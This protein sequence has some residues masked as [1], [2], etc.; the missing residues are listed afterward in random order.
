ML[1]DAIARVS[2]SRDADSLLDH[3]V[4]TAVSA[5]GAERGFLLLR[6]GADATPQVRVARDRKGRP[7]PAGTSPQSGRLQPMTPIPKSL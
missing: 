7:V 4:D 2:E 5:L 3:I 6:P 1:L